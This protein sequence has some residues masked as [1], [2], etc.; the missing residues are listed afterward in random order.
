MQ[1]LCTASKAV[2]HGTGSMLDSMWNI[3]LWIFQA[4]LDCSI[5][6]ECRNELYAASTDACLSTF[7]DSWQ[8][9]QSLSPSLE[10]WHE[11]PAVCMSEWHPA[12]TTNAVN[13]IS[14][15]LHGCIRLLSYKGNPAASIWRFG[16]A[17]VVLLIYT[18]WWY[19]YLK[20]VNIPTKFLN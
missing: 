5:R 6:L 2:S 13:S 14:V 17:A 20:V 9:K 12:A 11:W 7:A 3:I 16:R 19:Q 15:K 10:C 1:N 8:A 18:E 4:P